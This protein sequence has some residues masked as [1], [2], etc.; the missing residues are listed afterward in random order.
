MAAM[1]KEYVCDENMHLGLK[2]EKKFQKFSKISKKCPNFFK[3][4]FQLQALIRT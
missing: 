4:S 1:A 2:L 3:N